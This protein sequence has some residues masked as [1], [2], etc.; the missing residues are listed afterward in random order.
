MGSDANPEKEWTPADHAFITDKDISGIKASP[1]NKLLAVGFG[2][3]NIRIFDVEQM[4]C[5]GDVEG[6]CYSSKDQTCISM[7]FSPDSKHLVYR[8]ENSIRI[9]DIDSKA[10]V[11]EITNEKRP[12][13]IEYSPNGK[14]LLVGNESD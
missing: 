13:T 1:N 10:K 2:K 4:T 5:V 12:V 14:F 7:D 8:W 11:M 3:E 6:C 9:Y